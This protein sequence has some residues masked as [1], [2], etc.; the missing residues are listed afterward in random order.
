MRKQ[1]LALFLTVLSLFSLVALAIGSSFNI[2]T[3]TSNST[4]SLNVTTR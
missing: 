3:S 2:A 1:E 4:T